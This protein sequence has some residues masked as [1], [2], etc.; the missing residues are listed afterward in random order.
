MLKGLELRDK[1]HDD[2]IDGADTPSQQVLE[3]FSIPK[4]KAILGKRKM[5]SFF[6]KNRDQNLASSTPSD[7]QVHRKLRL[8]SF[9]RP[10]LSVMEAMHLSGISGNGQSASLTKLTANKSIESTSATVDRSIFDYSFEDLLDRC[11]G[12]SI[13]SSAGKIHHSSEAKVQAGDRHVVGEEKLAL[14]TFLMFISYTTVLVKCSVSTIVCATIY[15]NRIT[16]LETEGIKLTCKNFRSIWL[17]CLMIAM[18]LFEDNPLEIDHY[19]IVFPASQQMLFDW[20]RMALEMLRSSLE[21]TNKVYAK[22][23]FSLRSPFVKMLGKE[24]VSRHLRKL[25]CY[26]NEQRLMNGTTAKDDLYISSAVA[27]PDPYSKDFRTKLH[28]SMIKVKVIG[29]K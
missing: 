15:M 29:R 13:V 2:K 23:M 12:P 7:H 28:Q 26:R 5:D 14:N 6:D 24:P 10:E 22:Y 8:E 16:Y 11:G 18:D 20:K 27:R 3:N 17:A 9:S 25:Q 1:D 21:I 19:S 4:E